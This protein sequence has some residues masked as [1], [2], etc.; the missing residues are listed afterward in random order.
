MA[1]YLTVA[2]RMRIESVDQRFKH[3]YILLIEEKK[4]NNMQ[5][6]GWLLYH[7]RV[8]GIIRS[9]SAQHRKVMG[10]MLYPKRVIAIDVK[11]CYVNYHVLLGVQDKRWASKGW[12][13]VI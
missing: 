3:K 11:C 4:I 5:I 12:F 7:T 13:S 6:V 1:K 9:E 10:S 2:F 8:R